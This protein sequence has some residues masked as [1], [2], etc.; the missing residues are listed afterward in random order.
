MIR[1][2]GGHSQRILRPKPVAL[3]ADIHEKILH[4]PAS[5]D[6]RNVWDTNFVT[7]VWNQAFCGSCYAFASREMLEAR[8]CTLTNNSQTP[9][10][11][12]RTLSLAASMLK[13]VTVTSRTSLQESMPKI[14]GWWKRHAFPTYTPNLH[15]NRRRTASVTPPPCTSMWEASLG[16][17]VKPWGNLSWFIM[18]PWQLLLKS[19]LLPPL[20]QGDLLPPWSERP[21]QRLWAD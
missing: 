15:A 21:F 18:G 2:G 19:V 4:L 13:A 8:I 10:M 1:R 11:S 5:R 9:V 3:T 16:A 12:L 7:S 14:L 6:W 20:P 17:A